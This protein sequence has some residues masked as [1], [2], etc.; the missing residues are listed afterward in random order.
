MKYLVVTSWSPE[1]EKLY[2]QRWVETFRKYWPPDAGALVVTDEMI[3]A[4][5]EAKDFFERHADKKMQRGPGYNYR[6]DLVRIGLEKAMEANVDWLVW[7]DGDVVT[8][9]SI[10]AETLADWLPDDKNFVYLSR[11]ETWDHPECGFM[12]FN[13]NHSN[14]VQKI[15]ETWTSDAVLGFSE[16]HDS[17]VIGEMAKKID[18]KHDLCPRSDGLEAFRAS[19]L[20]PYLTHLKGN[21][22][23]VAERG[24]HGD[25]AVREQ[26]KDFRNRYELLSALVEHF[27]PKRIAEVGTWNGERAKLLAA[28]AHKAHGGDVFYIGYDLFES[29]SP[30]IDAKELNVKRH[31]SLKEVTA[32]LEAFKAENPWFEFVLRPGDTWDTLSQTNA[33]SAD[34][35]YIDGGHSIETIRHDFEAFKSPAIVLDD[36]YHPE[37][38]HPDIEK[39][40]VNK[41]VRAA[42]AFGPI[43]PVQGGGGVSL[44]YIGSSPLPVWALRASTKDEVKAITGGAFDGN[45]VLKTRNCRPEEE[46]RENIKTNLQKIKQW[47]RPAKAHL[48]PLVLVSAGESL[49]TPET[50][51]ELRRWQSSGASI[52]CV[53]HSHNRLIELGIIPWACVLLDPRPHKGPSTHGFAREDM[54]AN[55]HPGVRYLLASMVDPTVVVGLL[56]KEADV[57]GW[58]AAVGA[59]EKDIIPAGH[60]LV[61]G[62]STSVMR[63]ISLGWMMGYRL[64]KTYAMDSCH[65]DPSKL[66]LTAKNPDGTPRY[67]QINVAA[68]EQKAEF[69]TDRD[70]LAQAQDYTRLL[71][72]NPMLEIEALGTGMVPYI[73]KLS[74]GNSKPFEEVYGFPPS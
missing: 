27:Q 48:T 28:A 45:V 41:A 46:I 62:G 33:V 10:K 16:T 35:V 68:G 6:M 21:Q 72:E 51:E 50:V 12:G 1:G 5:P 52:W 42:S 23:F 63:A 57:W 53:K 34:F 74:R 44:A 37:G 36:Y 8:T 54:L 24:Q 14:F 29:A 22:K 64:M 9:Q 56:A 43:D 60:N 11:R 67:F 19:P 31:F 38:G 66:D 3:Y 39:Y 49:N 69:W 47:I 71:K 65:F 2:G 59:N 58:H 32:S 18:N 7:L 4:A 20:G 26:N 13:L 30:E 55:P 70:L 15:I 17:H 61:P 40:G 73:H 25:V